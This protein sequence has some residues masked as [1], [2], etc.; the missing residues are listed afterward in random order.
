MNFVLVCVHAY[1]RFMSC[2]ACMCLCVCVCVGGGGGVQ[3]GVSNT[4]YASVVNYTY[5]IFIHLICFVH[6]RNM[7]KQFY[8]SSFLF[9]ALTQF[10]ELSEDVC[11]LCLCAVVV[12]LYSCCVVVH[13]NMVQMHNAKN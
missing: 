2:S 9:G 12:S 8:T 7:I 5:L 13:F 11:L 1:M 10:G 4:G 3:V 6:L